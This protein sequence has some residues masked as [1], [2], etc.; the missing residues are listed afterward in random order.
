[1][2]NA[3]PITLNDG[4]SDVTFSPDVVSSTHVRFQDLSE[5][6][7]DLRK[8]VHFDRPTGT[9]AIRRSVRI[10][11]PLPRSDG[12]GN[13]LPPLMASVKVEFVA[14]TASTLVE[15]EAI[16]KL[17]ADSLSKAAVTGIFTSPEWV[18]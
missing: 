1:M 17:V 14:P 4:T 13:A 9:G 3:S 8:L 18:W 11:T 2:P 16:V 15:R 7:I 12:N 5:G 6:R 10:N